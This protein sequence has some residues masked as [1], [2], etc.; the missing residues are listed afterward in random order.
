MGCFMLSQHSK[1]LLFCFLAAVLWSFSGVGVKALGEL[2]AFA[3]SG[4]RSLFTVL[5][6]SAFL[7]FQKQSFW[8]HFKKKSVWLAAVVYM[9]MIF[10]FITATQE[11]TAANAILLQY[12]APIHVMILSGFFLHEKPQKKDFYAIFFVFIGVV[13]FFAEDLSSKGLMGNLM[14]LLS[15]FLCGCSFLCQRFLGKNSKTGENTGLSSIILGNI[16]VVFVSLP[17]LIQEPLWNFPS[18]PILVLL[19]VFQLGLAFIFFTRG[20]PWVSAIEAIILSILEAI[21]NPIW[22]IL[23]IGEKPSF[24]ALLGG[25]VILV[26]VFIYSTAGYRKKIKSS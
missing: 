4:G 9:L 6:L 18:L 16:L 13:M 24:M 20:I 21:L 11:T 14:A 12:T 3:I 19:G 23:V 10:S 22:V 17:Q 15:G 25:S 8:Q 7:C 1:G 2:S 5:F 26:T